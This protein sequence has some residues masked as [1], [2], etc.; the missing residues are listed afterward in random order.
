[1]GE[2]PFS[3]GT[4][5]RQD[6]SSGSKENSTAT[7]GRLFRFEHKWNGHKLTHYLAILT[8]EVCFSKMHPQVL[9]HQEITLWQT[10][11]SMP[12][13]HNNAYDNPQ[14]LNVNSQGHLI[15]T[16]AFPPICTIPISLALNKC[17]AGMWVN[18]WWLGLD[19]F[20][21][22]QVSEDNED[23]HCSPHPAFISV[24]LC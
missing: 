8:H 20:K 22:T 3:T 6:T 2:S 11:H 18:K 10:L 13:R 17:L 15:S 16:F 12:W 14:A 1:V 9:Y 4:W 19:R 5:Y 23:T 24:F 21:R 7:L